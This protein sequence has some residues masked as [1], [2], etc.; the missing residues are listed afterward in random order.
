MKREEEEEGDKRKQALNFSEIPQAG[1]TWKQIQD[2][3]CNT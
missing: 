2:I 1:K 3:I